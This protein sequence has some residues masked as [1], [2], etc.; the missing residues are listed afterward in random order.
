MH[1]FALVAGL[2]LC[3]AAT[4]ASAERPSAAAR[5][6]FR[7]G[8][9][10][11]DFA[12][13]MQTWEGDVERIGFEPEADADCHWASDTRLS[14]AFGRRPLVK[15]TRYRVLLPEG[16][17]TQSGDALPAM[18]LSAETERPRV[19]ASIESWG[20]GRPRIALYVEQPVGEHALASVLR[21]SLGGRQTPVRLQRLPDR[22]WPR[23]EH[24][25][26][27]LPER[28]SPDTELELAVIPGLVSREG[29]LPGTQREELLNA[30]IDESFRLRG[31]ACSGAQHPVLREARDGDLAITCFPGETV[32][33]FF[34]RSLDDASL[35][36]WRMRWPKQA[37][38]EDRGKEGSG[39]ARIA[40]GSVRVAPG[41]WIE[42][43]IEA[44]RARTALPDANGLRSDRGFALPASR[45]EI[46][47]AEPRPMLAAPHRRNLMDAERSPEALAE[48]TQAS[49]VPVRMV[50]V[51]AQPRRGTFS[52]PEAGDAAVPIAS[53]AT[54]ATL[55]EGGWAAWSFSGDT[56]RSTG[57]PVQ[58]AAPDFDLFAVVGTRQVLAW[59]N[60]W[61]GEA[62]VGAAVELL[63]M[64]NEE[65]EPRVVARGTTDADGT[66]LLALPEGLALPR[67][68][69]RKAPFPKWLLRAQYGRGKAT[70][71]AVLP[72]EANTYYS[73]LG[74]E[75]R[76]ETWGVSDRPM[77]RSGDTVR[78][79]LW[80]R[81]AAD[82]RLSAPA[83]GG[84]VELVLSE[85]SGN[86]TIR[87]WK[88]E[89]GA[90]HGLSGEIVL[91]VHL[92]DGNYCIGEYRDFATQGVCFFVGT[93]RAQDL[94]AKAEMPATVLRDGDLLKVDISAGY[95]SGGA[96]AAVPV[97]EPLAY[98]V[99]LRFG[100][101]YPQYEDFE[102]AYGGH[103]AA[104][105]SGMEGATLHTDVDGKAHGEWPLILERR[106][107]G[108]PAFGRVNFSA[109]A[110]L[111]D[112]EGSV[113]NA[114]TA[115]YAH[116]D[117]Y[118]GLR[119]EPRWI[120]ASG[121]ITL[122]AV[123]ADADGR[124]ISGADVEVEIGYRP[125]SAVEPTEIVH[126]CRLQ[127]RRE[128]RCDFARD[129]SG[130]YRFTARSG[131]AAPVHLDRYIWVHGREGD[132]DQ[133]T[134]PELRL[135]SES[136]APGDPVRAL[137]QQGSDRAQALFVFAAGRT[138]LARRVVP[139]VA[140]SQEIELATDPDWPAEFELKAYVRTA[141]AP[142]ADG[143]R[144]PSKIETLELDVERKREPVSAGVSLTLDEATQPG[145]RV[146]LVLRNRSREPREVTLAV[147]DDALIS[148]AGEQ[149]DAFDPA[150]S[151]W[152]MRRD[153]GDLYVESFAAWNDEPWRRLLGWGERVMPRPECE[154]EAVARPYCAA[155]SDGDIRTLDAVAVNAEARFNPIDVSSV[156]ST[157]VLSAEQ[158]A[159]TP[160]A[161]DQTTVALLAPGTVQSAPAP[162]LDTV[163]VVGSG[164]INAAIPSGPP[165]ADGERL[166]AIRGQRAM[167][168]VRVRQRF[169]DTALWQPGL[170]L[171]PDE[172]RRIA[173]DL[174]D[175]LTRWRAVAWVNDTDDLFERVD[176]TVQAGLPVEV[177]LQAPVRLYPG[178]SAR[179]AA[180]VRHTDGATVIAHTALEVGGEV[181]A[182]SP[183]AHRESLSLP[184]RGQASFGATISPQAA[185]SLL[186]VARAQTPAGSD[187]VAAGIDVASSLI[188]AARVQ[189]GW[190]DADQISLTLP[191]LPQGATEAKLRVSLVRGDAG[192]VERWS[193]DLRDY[194]H[195]CWEQILSRAVG[196]A[197]ALRRGD[198]SWPDAADAV[199]E[200]LDN[201]GVFQSGQGGFRYF[202][203]SEMMNDHGE[204]LRS[205]EPDVALTAYTLRALAQLRGLGHAVDPDIEARARVFLKSVLDLKKT[206][207]ADPE[208]AYALTGNLTES[209]EPA[210]RIW[211]GWD[212]LPVGAR[213]ATAHALA[214]M[215]RPEAAVAV[216]RLW[217]GA[218][219]Q[220]RAR[221]MTRET[222]ARW[223]SSPLREQCAMLDLLRAHPTLAPAGAVREL[224]AGLSDL[225]AGGAS[226]TDT[227]SASVCL[228][229]LSANHAERDEALGADIAL[230]AQRATLLLEPGQQRAEWE[231]A[232][233]ADAVLRIGASR[234][235]HSPV[236]FIVRQE[237]REDAR[238]ADQAAVGLR[239]SRRLEV[240]RDSRWI[241]VD[242]AQVRVGDWLRITL[243]IDNAAP[244]YFV[245]VSDSVAGGLQPT[246]LSLKGIAGLA[247]ERLSDLGSPAFGTRRLDP[248]TPRFYAESLPAGR[249]EIH[250]FARA[251]NAGDFLAA[252]AL[253]ELMYGDATRARTAADR[254][255]IV[256]PEAGPGP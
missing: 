14:C 58:F 105:V 16:L 149:W 195:R 17:A 28:K 19:T 211:A 2:L 146:W 111:S 184:A 206:S 83:R 145:G 96:A 152:L 251:G 183:L 81:E 9:L 7:Y 115:V 98:V 228:M 23:G 194:P 212:H 224:R 41:A 77:Y 13:P 129:K 93:Y 97:L 36:E 63:R 88:A 6:E 128:Q 3:V 82:G 132:S 159:R 76:R 31:G 189:A 27:M 207:T 112:R 217:R 18:S 120:R 140:K 187:A 174:P 225:Y 208:Q 181:L 55:A 213:I 100:T 10:H 170:R 142:G 220:G 155:K 192:L 177:R 229:A 144:A 60:G 121:A 91:P 196:A 79:R 153:Y 90:D 253:V 59:A 106:T 68:L 165:Q 179:L 185:G 107:E 198:R 205:P 124:E 74:E 5:A 176:A 48:A 15:A 193:A 158:I 151:G 67:E 44:P 231:G 94:W 69:D 243:T 29:P 147:I 92:P 57:F 182:E 61:S 95:Y 226:S 191:A 22:N 104:E 131:D 123:V 109:E 25:A 137:L 210:L 256:A 135:V 188:D 232:A 119:M 72:L 186:A 222:A 56:A 216:E 108:P 45:I 148:L 86:K 255:S 134:E 40:A 46:A 160:L 49:P 133:A 20:D 156:E 235:G 167:A 197:L 118:V 54:Q 203:E 64:E 78:Y 8:Q 62:V 30:I 24:Y 219:V 126:R 84:S 190:L 178:D 245:A 116:F 87:R 247:L 53:A 138:V 204:F 70:E 34:S 163:T 141:G 164:A 35:R 139:I 32:R 180:N 254:L 175:N 171:A 230:G 136:G 80:Q 38:F 21:L 101:Q 33:L 12:D 65:A 125:Y 150:R 127:A 47:T 252:P 238:R 154:G 214:D 227:Q 172:T 162:G 122:E 51:G 242:D 99:P 89:F 117:R 173:L 42:L 75:R 209:A 239:V 166:N 200:A 223:M 244:R 11:I 52:T 215:H 37:V 50:G 249:H 1:R 4:A 157:T 110:R 143:L 113:A 221:L 169:A 237:Y 71:R 236:A 26:L 102:F 103:D 130:I 218:Q 233:P 248:R 114:E 43:R 168:S 202:V 241:G 161:R 246:D 240:L 250:Y 201:V 199:A 39:G 85:D 73:N 66:A 234:A